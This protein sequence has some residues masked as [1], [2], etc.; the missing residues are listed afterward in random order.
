MTNLLSAD[1]L[2]RKIFIFNDRQLLFAF[3]RTTL[4]FLVRMQ[5]HDAPKERKLRF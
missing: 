1:L 5:S 2:Y 3:K 4:Q